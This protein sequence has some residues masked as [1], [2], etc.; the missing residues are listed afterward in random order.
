MIEVY[1]KVEEE[2]IDACA[3]TDKVNNEAVRALATWEI[4][5]NYS[6]GMISQNITNHIYIIFITITINKIFLT[7]RKPK[8]MI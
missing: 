3:E 4:Y 7:H 5:R 8:K 2:T 6:S 1:K